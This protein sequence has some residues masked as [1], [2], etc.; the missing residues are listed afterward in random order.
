[1]R[2]Y[3]SIMLSTSSSVVTEI[4]ASS[5]SFGSWYLTVT[6]LIWRAWRGG[7][8]KWWRVAR[9]QFWCRRRRNGAG[10]RGAAGGSS[11]RSCT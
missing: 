2:S 11:R 5:S 1:M 8:R 10:Y 6:L 9:R 4:R 3:S 7:S